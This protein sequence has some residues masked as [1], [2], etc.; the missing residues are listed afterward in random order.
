MKLFRSAYYILIKCVSQV[1]FYTK[2]LLKLILPNFRKLYHRQLICKDYP[3]C[4]QKVYITGS[5]IVEIGS[6]CSLGY[7]L[8]GHFFRGYIELQARFRNSKIV[9]GNNIYSNNNLWICASNYIEIG[10]DTLIGQGVSFMDHE[11]HGIKPED[12]RKIGRIGSIKI[13]KNVWI[14][15]NVTI[16]KNTEIGDN[17]I[18]AAGA[19]VSGKFDA[20]IIIGG[21]PAKIIKPLE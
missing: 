8:G 19:V 13:G 10:D 21:I 16:L 17:T 11:A 4:Y 12:R 2:V 3:K 9:L 5:G 14:G 1:R 15:N 20:N 18:I 7:K 6:N